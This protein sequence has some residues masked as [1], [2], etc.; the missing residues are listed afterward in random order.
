MANITM[1]VLTC[2]YLHVP[3]M[4]E[5]ATI[6]SGPSG[7]YRLQVQINFYI[8]YRKCFNCRYILERGKANDLIILGHDLVILGR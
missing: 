2:L 8:I 4:A 5:V 1:Q 7:W 3:T 6:A